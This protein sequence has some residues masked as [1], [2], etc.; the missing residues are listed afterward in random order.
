V[1]TSSIADQEVLHRRGLLP[2]L[3][4]VKP[5]GL[6]DFLRTVRSIEAFWMQA[7]GA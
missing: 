6:D 2:G 7:A 4:L 1:P 5:V 3:Y